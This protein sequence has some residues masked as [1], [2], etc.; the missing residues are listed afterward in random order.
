[1]VTSNH[2]VLLAFTR[3]EI[4]GFAPNGSGSGNRYKIQPVIRGAGRGSD[5]EMSQVRDHIY[6]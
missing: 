2:L 3:D 1:M 5:L 4:V 6:T